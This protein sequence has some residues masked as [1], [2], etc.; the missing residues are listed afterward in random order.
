MDL[1]DPS[2]LVDY[3]L[4][5]PDQRVEDACSSAL[6]ECG[7][8]RRKAKI[9]AREFTEAIV[10]NASDSAEYADELLAVVERLLR[11]RGE[12]EVAE[13]LQGAR[14]AI[15]HGIHVARAVTGVGVE[16]LGAGGAVN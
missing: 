12:P 13:Q 9:A 6:Q 1:D 7:I 3:I 11:D 14:Q 2:T 8:S 4:D 10:I 5:H 15:A 16:S